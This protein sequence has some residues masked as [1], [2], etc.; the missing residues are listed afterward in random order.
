[1]P[2]LM[3]AFLIHHGQVHSQPNHYAGHIAQ[4]KP[5]KP[6]DEKKK[7]HLPP[8]FDIELVAAE[9]DLFKPM[10]LAFDER[11]RL[12]VTDTLEY[13]IPVRGK[14]KPRDSV[15]IL[16][17][18]GPDGR[19]RKITTFADG[20]NI[21]IGVLP[22]STSQA[23][24]YSIPNVLLLTDT[25]GDGR[26]DQR[27]VLLNT[28]GTRDTHGM[29]NNFTWGFD[30][31]IYA[32][33][34]FSNTSTV[35]GTDG[36]KITMQSGNVY[37]FK[38]DGSHV[39]YF[40][41]GQVNPFGLAFDPLG[42]L[43][44]SDCHTKPIY[45][46][47]RGG[48]YPSFG[49]PHDGLG[50]AP[51]MMTHSHGS[52]AIAGLVHYEADHFPKEYQ[53]TT[54]LGNVVTNRINHDRIEWNGATPRAIR[55]PD[56]L[57]CDDPWFRPVDVQLGLDGSLYVADFY[58]SIIGHYEVPLDHPKRD[59]HRGRIWRI[60]YRGKDGKNRPQQSRADWSKS[61]MDELIQDLSHSNLQ[62]RILATNQLVKRGGDEGIKAIL[63]LLD[64]EP[65]ITQRIHALWVLHR[66]KKLDDK[67]IGQ[68]L[69]DEASEVQVHALR[70]LTESENLSMSLQKNVHSL[71]SNANA[72]V[73]RAAAEC[74]GQQPEL[75]NVLPLIKLKQQI[76]KEDTHLLHVV[77]MALRD[78]V[79][80]VMLS[81]VDR[82]WTKVESQALADVVP[83]TTGSRP[84]DLLLS[85]LKDHTPKGPALH[86]MVRHVASHGDKKHRKRILLLLRENYHED[87]G[88]LARLILSA[89]Q[90]MQEAGTSFSDEAREWAV[91]FTGMLLTS[92][93][94]E[95]MRAALNLAKALRIRE[96]RKTLLMIASDETFTVADRSQA[97]EALVAVDPPEAIP[98][99][100]KM[101]S[102]RSA[103]AEI[104][105]QVASLLGGL[106]HVEARKALLNGLL[107]A[108]ANEQRTIALG[109]VN[110]KAG[111]ETLLQNVKNGKA[112]AR[113]LQ[114]RAV[115]ARLQRHRIPNLKDQIT[116]LTR[117]V[118]PLDA[119]IRTL[120]QSRAKTYLAQKTDVMMGQKIFANRCANCHQ[121]NNQGA[122]IG[123]QLDGIGA[124]GIER[125]FE[126]V[127]DPSRNVDQQFRT[128]TVQLKKGQTLTGLLVKV[129]GEVLVLADEKG[130]EKRIPKA[131]VEQQ[132]VLNLSPMPGNFADQIPESELYHL[133]RYLLHQKAKE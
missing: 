65:T 42:N 18:F 62:V 27:K 23:I 39:E 6:L 86:L 99:L 94:P 111:S 45:Q 117:N 82:P 128:T 29:T 125:I 126:D 108:S 124:R 121:I 75:D 48:W 66:T 133:M 1:M 112:S 56:F 91:K 104:R 26:A 11:G 9:P 7:F 41:H 122:K 114:D 123:P 119:K 85:H 97:L 37:R 10:N 98:P 89:H 53:G 20:L 60:V 74:L 131:S 88:A 46:L 83:G 59:R 115:L 109:L 64:S 72:H 5:L 50:F 52:T 21:P 13:P 78:Q 132:M 2:F 77:R 55:Q 36:S 47:L 120:I 14:G 34:G 58:N 57:K 79:Q 118:P 107:L 24:V 129:E 44:S 40:T 25:N 33:H 90:G 3:V 106:N 54:F 31:W 49:K 70:T 113:L 15:K 8:G 116:K 102:D 73:Q 12:W 130:V 19:A 69:K 67:L 84:V 35:V 4:T 32:C 51:A 81:N 38:P 28:F 63:K 127:L 22:L 92:K 61:T 103:R 71:L 17:D 101:L 30:G 76:P 105:S 80:H 95:R 16:E 100:R 87:A 43:Y 96:L 68:F 93:K 110:S